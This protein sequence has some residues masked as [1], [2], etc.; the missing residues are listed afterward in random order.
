LRTV[1][2]LVIVI[3]LEFG[4]WDLVLC[5][6]EPYAILEPMKLSD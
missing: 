3:C 2:N 6:I 5:I 4:I 1:G